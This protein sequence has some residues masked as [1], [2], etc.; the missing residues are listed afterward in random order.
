[1]S[2]HAEGLYYISL[3]SLS[4]AVR[5][6][7]DC[8]VAAMAALSIG[9]V[10]KEPHVGARGVSSIIFRV[11]PNYIVV[12]PFNIKGGAR[13][14]IQYGRQ[15]VADTSRSQVGSYIYVSAFCAA[16][17]VKAYLYCVRAVYS[18]VGAAEAFRGRSQG[19][20]VR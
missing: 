2:A 9:H 6:H 19:I 17:C 18:K 16:N 20:C 10:R 7:L 15:R 12:P 3:H 11:A 4:Y 5:N 14:A 1:M 13:L 8:N